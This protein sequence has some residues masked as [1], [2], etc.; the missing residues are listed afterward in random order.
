MEEL[1]K[2]LI[3]LLAGYLYG[4]NHAREKYSQKKETKNENKYK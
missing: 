4:Y 2:V 1:A 3:I